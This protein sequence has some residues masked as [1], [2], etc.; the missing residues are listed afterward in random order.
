LIII[1]T[2]M[3][4]G[5]FRNSVGFPAMNLKMRKTQYDTVSWKKML[6][7]MSDVNYAGER[8]EALNLEDFL[9]WH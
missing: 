7:N 2:T 6:R 5:G 1:F 3:V 4:L 9:A 8:L